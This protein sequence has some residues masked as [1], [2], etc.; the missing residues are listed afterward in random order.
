MVSQPTPRFLWSADGEVPGARYR[1]R[2]V[3]VDGA[4]AVAAL[5]SGFPAW[6]ATIT[7]TSAF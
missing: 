5:Q 1:I 7:G 3:K 4:S 2:V 6:E